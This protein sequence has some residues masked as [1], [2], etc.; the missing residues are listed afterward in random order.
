MQARIQI[1]LAPSPGLGNSHIIMKIDPTGPSGP[2]AI[3]RKRKTAKSGS[4]DF[5]GAID[6]ESSPAD[7]S[8][9]TGTAPVSPSSSVLLA[10]EVGDETTERNRARSRGLAILDHLDQL[11]EAILKGE[12]SSRILT[13]MGQLTNA[14]REAVNDPRLHEILDEIELR[15]Q[16]ELA[17]HQTR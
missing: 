2:K 16:V 12:I 8:V 5:S 13:D 4:A 15:A 7:A 9:V 10:Q 14:Q 3:E 11:R 17:K 1:T 6:A